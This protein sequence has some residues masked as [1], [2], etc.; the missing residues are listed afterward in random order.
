MW[1]GKDWQGVCWRYCRRFH[2]WNSL[3]CNLFWRCNCC[4]IKHNLFSRMRRINDSDRADFHCICGS[5]C[6]SLFCRNEKVDQGSL[7][8]NYCIHE[9][10]FLS[11]YV[12]YLRRIT[13]WNGSLVCF[14]YYHKCFNAQWN[15]VFC[16]SL[17]DFNILSSPSSPSDTKCPTSVIFITCFKV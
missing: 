17:A 11:C 14:L 16:S 10:C 4:F 6:N 12:F 2:E 1:C 15:G 8:N 13:K 5:C 7:N 3:Q 9:S